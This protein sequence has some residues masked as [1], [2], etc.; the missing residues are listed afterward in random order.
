MLLALGL[1]LVLAKLG[2]LGSFAC[3]LIHHMTLA[4]PVAVAILCSRR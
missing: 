3:V 4:N 1:L 2:L